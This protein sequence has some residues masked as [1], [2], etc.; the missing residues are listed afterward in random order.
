[1]GNYRGARLLVRRLSLDRRLTC[2]LG[3]CVRPAV[4]GMSIA[5]PPFYL[6]PGD[7]HGVAFP[8]K[9]SPRAFSETIGSCVSRKCICTAPCARPGFRTTYALFFS[10]SHGVVRRRKLGST[11]WPNPCR[12]S[13]VTCSFQMAYSDNLTIVTGDT[14]RPPS[15]ILWG[16]KTRICK[17]GNLAGR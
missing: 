12:P 11:G 15:R 8:L 5:G 13:H 2:T 3:M 17:E 1:V 4:L 7:R 16:S 14:R 6:S 9:A 10:A